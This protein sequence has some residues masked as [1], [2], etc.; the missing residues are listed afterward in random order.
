MADDDAAKNT[1]TSNTVLA[2]ML[3]NLTA[4]MEERFD[5]QKDQL[6]K[7][8]GRSS[9][10]EKAIIA[11][12]GQSNRNTDDIKNLKQRGYFW[13]GF[14]TIAIAVATLFGIGTRQ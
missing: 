9:E 3:E 7:I 13:D 11:I 12:K 4:R 10:N 1:R 5:E 2:V 8:N 6:R 14:N